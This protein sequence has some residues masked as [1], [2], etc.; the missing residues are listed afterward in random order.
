MPRILGFPFHI[1]LNKRLYSFHF[2][3]FL[4]FSNKNSICLHISKIHMHVHGTVK[5]QNKSS[6]LTHLKYEDPQYNWLQV[7]YLGSA[8]INACVIKLVYHAIIQAESKSQQKKQF[9]TSKYDRYS[10]GVSGNPF[11]EPTL[12]KFSFS[13][14]RLW[15]VPES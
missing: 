13:C 6:L 15:E 7:Q 12:L 2:H 8:E 4:Y 10:M 9:Y 5:K 3:I 1:F 14:C 11:T